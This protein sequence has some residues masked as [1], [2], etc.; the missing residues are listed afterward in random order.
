M[1]TDRAGSEGPSSPYNL[2]VLV[3]G[4]DVRIEETSHKRRWWET[5][6]E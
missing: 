1:M 5:E 4:V 3:C 2:G 6:M